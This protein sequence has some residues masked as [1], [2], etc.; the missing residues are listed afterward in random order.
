MTAEEFTKMQDEA[1]A[2]VL[3]G[4]PVLG[5]HGAFTE[6]LKKFVESALEAE[7]ESHLSKEERSKGNKRNGYG[8]KKLQTSLGTIDI[9]PPFDRHSTF[10]PQIVKKRE[11]IMAE[12]FSHQILSLYSSGMSTR[13]ISK[14]IEDLYGSSISASTISEITDKI[15]PEIKQWQSRPLESVYPIVFMDAIH[16]KVREEG[17]V[18]SKAI[19]SIL[20]VN[21]DGMKEILGLYSSENES[22]RYW[23][24][25]LSDLKNRGLEDICIACIDNLSGFAKAIE[26]IYPQCEIQP[27]IIHQ[28]RN[29]NKYVSD[30]DKKE[31]NTDLRAVYGAVSKDM[32][33]F[34]LDKLEQKWGKKHPSVI[35]SWRNNW[36]L[37]SNFFKY[38]KSIRKLIYTTNIVE[39]YHRQLRQV[40]KNK[41]SFS[42]EMSLIKLLYLKIDKI[43]KSPKG[44]ILGWKSIYQ[45]LEIH[46]GAERLNR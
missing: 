29:S 14:H 31:F 15:I 28:I 25:V 45:Q 43:S 5:E 9:E 16:F 3:K 44:P 26:S 46:F 40:S 7:I 2:K 13:D 21:R 38:E 39:G 18:K 37:L 8:K 35:R 42:T 12:S 11:S 10:D 20:G 23:L 30:K 19:Y 22:S 27:C 33:E 4:G 17:Q 34:A 6:L 1:L 24:E 41:G 36:D 32:A